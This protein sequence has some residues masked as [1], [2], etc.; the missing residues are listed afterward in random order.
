ML[1]MRKGGLSFPFRIPFT[2]RGK[3]KLIELRR[4]NSINYKN[5]PEGKNFFLVNSISGKSND[6]CYVGYV[7]NKKYYYKI[8]TC[9]KISIVNNKMIRKTDE[10]EILKNYFLKYP[11]GK[12][13]CKIWY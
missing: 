11:A 7:N 10:K 5:A 2:N 6:F 13:V 9:S 3:R 4:G 1:A 12:K 8:D